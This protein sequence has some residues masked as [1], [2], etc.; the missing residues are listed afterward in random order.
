MKRKVYLF[1]LIIAWGFLAQ[2]C[3]Y[4]QEYDNVANVKSIE[5]NKSSPDYIKA[6]QDAL[7]KVIGSVIKGFPTE[8]VYSNTWA[9]YEYDN[10]IPA[11]VMLRYERRLRFLLNA[12]RLLEE[13]YTLD[14]GMTLIA[15]HEAFHLVLGRGTS[16]SE[17]HTYMLNNVEYHKLIK[18]FIGCSNLAEARSLAFLGTEEYHNLTKAQRDFIQFIAES[19]NVKIK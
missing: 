8:Q 15:L 5:V 7:A 19:Y 6:F 17:G 18:S 9:T 13:G 1:L 3:L 2:S 4:E 14:K 12:E 16:N 10:D 11:I